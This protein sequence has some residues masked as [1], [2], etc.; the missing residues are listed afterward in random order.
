MILREGYLYNMNVLKLISITIRYYHYSYIQYKIKYCTNHFFLFLIQI[1]TNIVA[2][3]FSESV[4]YL[5]S[6]YIHEASSIQ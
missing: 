4:C 6:V 1:S 5:S 2:T 3:K